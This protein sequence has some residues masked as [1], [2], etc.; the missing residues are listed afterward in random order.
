MFQLISLICY[1]FLFAYL[2]FLD[3]DFFK[4][5]CVYLIF[6]DIFLIHLYF[7]FIFYIDELKK[8]SDNISNM[9]S[10]A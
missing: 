6:E 1:F 4:L 8:N 7:V 3:K 10:I 9:C 5:F 2:S